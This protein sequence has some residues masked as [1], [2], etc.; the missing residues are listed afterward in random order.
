MIGDLSV[1]EEFGFAGDVVRGIMA[2]VEQDKV[3]ETV[4]GTGV[5]HSIEE[6][7]DICFAMYNLNWQNHVETLPGFSSEYSI[8]VSDP[9]TIFSLGWHPEADIHSLGKMMNG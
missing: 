1:K 9:A 3:Y 6:W 8:L 2:L 5:A 7:V 4:I